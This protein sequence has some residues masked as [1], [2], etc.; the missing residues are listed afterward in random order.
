MNKKQ[1]TL[2]VVLNIFLVLLG[3][4]IIRGLTN[5][6]LKSF[7]TSV[8]SSLGTQVNDIKKSSFLSLQSS[9]I[10]TVATAKESVVTITISKDV[11]FYV[12][13]PS[14]LNGP[15]SIQQQTA[16]I[17]WWSWILISKNGYIITNKHVVQDA[18]A[19]YSVTLYDGKTYN[20]D[21]IRFDDLLDIAILKIVD[22]EGKNP[23]TIPTA[24]FLPLATQVEV[25][26]F[27]LAIGNVLSK[28]PNT[29]TMGII[30]S[31]NKQLTINGNNLYVGLYQTDAQANPG[32]SGG[33]LL[34]IEG[35]T[36][37][38]I[39]AIDEGEGMTFALPLSK[40]FIESTIKSIESFGKI[41]R[42][43]IGIQYT[44]ITPA[45]KAEKKLTTDNGI[46][47]KD[48][49]SDLPAREAG[50]KEW[51]I[52]LSINKQ[53]I[54]AYVPFLYKLYTYIPGE[55]I[56]MDILRGTERLTLNV[57]LGWNIQ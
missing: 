35:N 42:P 8:K 39:T 5:S 47:I 38:I 30:W 37:G 29:V 41:S 21:K 57:V 45:I 26:Q 43:I 10:Q 33:P 50:L 12:E 14:Q 36:I 28:Y 31:K 53:E 52:I 22:S 3:G 54:H 24:S 46:Y 6:R 23:T 55:T 19:K 40:E 16:K 1:M 32:N 20:V 13:D 44:E 48:V 18:A 15:G 2:V 9:L 51:D 25:G 4:I 27:V 17:G 56:T 34:D 11:K 49:L 7:W